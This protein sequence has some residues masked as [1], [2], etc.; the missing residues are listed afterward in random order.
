VTPRGEWPVSDDER[1]SAMAFPPLKQSGSSRH[2]HTPPKNPG[3][4][5]K[6]RKS[7]AGRITQFLSSAKY[8]FRLAAKRFKNE[9]AKALNNYHSWADIKRKEREAA[10]PALGELR[11]TANASKLGQAMLNADG[12]SKHLFNKYLN[13]FID[14]DH[15]LERLDKFT[16]EE[17]FTLQFADHR[18]FKGL[19]ASS[20]YDLFRETLKN[21][22]SKGGIRQMFLY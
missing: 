1:Q 10:N 9:P 14:D 16:F 5:P 18:D 6:E 4:A 8:P 13:E 17:A 12:N 7:I 2:V 3:N 15:A 19:I 20:S 21:A 11:K 22:E